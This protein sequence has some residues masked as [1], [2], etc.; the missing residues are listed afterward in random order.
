MIITVFSMASSWESVKCSAN[1]RFM[2]YTLHKRKKKKER[3]VLGNTAAGPKGHLEIKLLSRLHLTD[4]REEA[5]L[6][7]MITD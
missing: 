2:I 3:K 1:K 4:F 7:T 6:K 5:M